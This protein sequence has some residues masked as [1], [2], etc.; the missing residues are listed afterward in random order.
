MKSTGET[1]WRRFAF[2]DNLWHFK[3]AESI[4]AIREGY[5]AD[6]LKKAM[7]DVKLHSASQ[8]AHSGG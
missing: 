4:K 8:Q 3:D 6:M 5:L 7:G 1:V 2:F